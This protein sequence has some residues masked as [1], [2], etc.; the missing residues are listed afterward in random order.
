MARKKPPE[1]HEVL[2]TSTWLLDNKTIMKLDG[3]KQDELPPPEPEKN[4]IVE[5][6]ITPLR[7]AELA[8]SN[9][10]KKTI[11]LPSIKSP[12]KKRTEIPSE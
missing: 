3:V 12:R 5:E 8:L 2:D 6:D 11:S 10:I 4:P 9:E 7:A 1:N